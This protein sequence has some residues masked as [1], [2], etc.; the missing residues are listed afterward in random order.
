MMRAWAEGHYYDAGID[1]HYFN[2]YKM[3]RAKTVNE[4]IIRNRYENNFKINDNYK[5]IT[6]FISLHSFSSDTPSQFRVLIRVVHIFS[7]AP[8]YY[9]NVYR[10]TAVCTFSTAIFR[11]DPFLEYKI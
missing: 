10:Y 1:M 7:A 6:C 11:R 3:I 9:L 4:R 8:K 5:I 2:R